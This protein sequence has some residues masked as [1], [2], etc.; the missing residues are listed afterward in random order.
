MVTK[1]RKGNRT[2]L[3]IEEWMAARELSDETLANRLDTSRT[4]VWRWR[5]QQ[6]RLN[7]EKI[8]QLAAALNLEPQDL[9]RPPA[10]AERPSVDALLRDASDEIVQ[11]AVE[12]VAILR[13]T[14]T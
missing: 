2:H 13:R 5:T 6:H 10:R 9:W 12:L 11:K 14:G 1:I 7:P 4:T 8:A 3:Y